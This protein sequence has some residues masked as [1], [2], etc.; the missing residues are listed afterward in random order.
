MTQGTSLAF[1]ML[2]ITAAT[3]FL[4]GCGGSSSDAIEPPKPNSHL[5]DVSQENL[6]VVKRV[7]S[8]SLYPAELSKIA[9]SGLNTLGLEES[10]FGTC[11]NRDGSFEITPQ[12]QVKGEFNANDTV[13]ISWSGCYSPQLDLRNTEGDLSIHIESVNYQQQVTELSAVIKYSNIV[14]NKYIKLDEGGVRESQSIS[15]EHS[16]KY[17]FENEAQQVHSFHTP[18]QTTQITPN[19]IINDVSIHQSHDL[20]NN[21]TS[22]DIG[23]LV[24]WTDKDTQLTYGITTESTLEGILGLGFQ[25]GELA[26]NGNA[27]QFL[28]LKPSLEEVESTV[29]ANT[30]K[31]FEG[32]D[33]DSTFIEAKESIFGDLGIIQPVLHNN[34]FD[35]QP[36][37]S[38]GLLTGLLTSSQPRPTNYVDIH[39]SSYRHLPHFT[40][41]SLGDSFVIYNS[42]SSLSSSPKDFVFTMTP[43]EAW[44]GDFETPVK[45]Y[46]QGHKLTLTPIESQ[47]GQGFVPGMTYSLNT[48]NNLNVLAIVTMAGSYDTS[49]V[50]IEELDD[51]FIE[52]KATIELSPKITG[53]FN[54]S[55]WFAHTNPDNN[56]SISKPYYTDTTISVDTSPKTIF[57]LELSLDLTHWNQS[58]YNPLA[59]IITPP[60]LE[61][62][63][64]YVAMQAVNSDKDKTYLQI[65]EYNNVKAQ[66]AKQLYIGEIEDS[67]DP[68][69]IISHEER[70]IYLGRDFISDGVWLELSGGRQI[71][72]TTT[73]YSKVKMHRRHVNFLEDCLVDRVEVVNT[74][75]DISG[76]RSD[77]TI[78]CNQES[79]YIKGFIHNF[80]E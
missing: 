27:E 78:H 8:I 56:L 47:P 41:F 73:E 42:N 80:Y 15:G 18:N 3:T 1:C 70:D 4:F 14:G 34:L 72:E 50:T 48:A 10:Y 71:S 65:S 11:S 39:N 69:W 31:H 21:L 9:V 28:K 24:K 33:I 29:V 26:I 19:F 74:Q 38:Y 46:R 66:T 59:T 22:I 55:I 68:E 49:E 37:Y 63:E 62:I 57:N 75:G 64:I 52:P 7:S 43:L 53:S 45:V 51:L 44:F 16:I 32:I 13:T 2:F 79:G 67:Y 35:L 40:D 58:H 17:V 54:Y 77:F 25:S 30:E 61:Q 60:N 12:R 20:Y 6:S 5:S 36:Y 23:A 76:T